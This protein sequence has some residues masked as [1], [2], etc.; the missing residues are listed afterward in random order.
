MKL[1]GFYYNSCIYESADALQSLH[2]T[3]A[4]AWRAKR[5]A[6]QDDFVESRENS[7][8]KPKGWTKGPAHHWNKRWFIKEIQVEGTEAS[9]GQPLRSK[10]AYWSKDQKE[11]IHS[12]NQSPENL[13]RESLINLVR[14]L[15]RRFIQLWDKVAF[16]RERNLVDYERLK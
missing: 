1:Y 2:L 4:E 6:Q 15:D 12:L 7:P 9:K 11:I 8:F 16:E 3:K 5:K 10:V 14:E 13:D